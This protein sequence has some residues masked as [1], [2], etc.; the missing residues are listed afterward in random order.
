M[1]Y[2]GDMWPEEVPHH[3]RDSPRRTALAVLEARAGRARRRT[4]MDS[5]VAQCTAAG[6]WRLLDAPV[7]RGNTEEPGTVAAGT[8][9][10]PACHGDRWVGSLEGHMRA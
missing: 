3:N 7:G 6:S 1:G 9:A 4:D 10:R 8:E 5:T 2:K